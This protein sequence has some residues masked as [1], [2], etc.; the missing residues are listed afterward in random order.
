MLSDYTGNTVD[1]SVQQRHFALRFICIEN[2]V[3]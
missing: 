1:E 2:I 3:N